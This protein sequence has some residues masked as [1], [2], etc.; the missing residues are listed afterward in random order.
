MYREGADWV[1]VYPPSY[2]E[3]SE[4]FHFLTAKDT[5]PLKMEFKPAVKVLSRK[6]VPTI[7]KPPPSSSGTKDVAS[8]VAQLRVNEGESDNDDDDG[9]K[10]EQLSAE[11]RR[12]K[13]QRDREEKQRR[14]EE[15]RERLFGSSNNLS[16]NSTPG[17]VT[18]PRAPG[19]GGSRP[20]TAGGDDEG[21]SSG[22]GNRRGRGR[23][24]RGTG[25]G[26]GVT[27][28]SKQTRA[29]NPQRD[30]EKEGK[31]QQQQQLF[32]P[33]Y[34]VK[35]DSVYVQRRMGAGVETKEAQSTVGAIEES[36]EPQQ[37]QQPPT[38]RAPRGPD[39]SGR[40]GNGFTVRGRGRGI[41]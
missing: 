28:E 7:A 2:S 10:K 17:D 27:R 9:T 19:G 3:S 34:T 14:Y 8:G 41:S 12:L 31:K 6:P 39:G 15:A 35:P 21:N 4:S 20:G 29:R 22:G 13:A 33:G 26:A 37:Q 40:G 36:G 16:G 23:G 25:A 5:V 11:E 1:S 18:P 38:I 24:G 30:K 32:D